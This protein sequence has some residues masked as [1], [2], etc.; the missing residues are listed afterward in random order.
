M[1]RLILENTGSIE[2]ADQAKKENIPNLRQSG[3]EK[4]IEGITSLEEV[5]RVI[6]E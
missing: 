2:L 5:N 3:I 1:T 6:R 4:V